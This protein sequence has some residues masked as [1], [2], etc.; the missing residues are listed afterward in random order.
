MLGSAWP[1]LA[2]SC[3]S[4]EPV[5]ACEIYQSTDVIFRGHVLDDNHDPT[6]GFLQTTLY[7]FKVLEAYKGL[8]PDTQQ[9][10]V[11]PGSMTT[12]YREFTRDHDYLVYAGGRQPAP[13]AVS[14]YRQLPPGSSV[15]QIPNAWKLLG[16][17][18]VYQVNECNPTRQIDEG[19][20]DLFFLRSS[21]KRKPS[22]GWIEGRAVQ[23][24]DSSW[25]A[26]RFVSAR[27]AVFTIT[28]QSRIHRTAVNPDGTFRIGPVPPGVYT[29]VAR[30]SLLGWGTVIEPR[31]EVPIGGCAVVQA[32]FATKSSISGRVVNFRGGPAHGIR[33]ELG[34]LLSDGKVRVIPA[35]WFDTGRDGRFTVS[36][37]PVGRIVLA[38]NLNGAPTSEMPFDPNYVPGTQDLSKAR[39]FEIKPGQEI[40]DIT[41]RLLKPLP[42]GNLYVHVKWPDGSAA[43]GGARASAYWNGSQAALVLRPAKTN[44]VKLRLALN[45][46]YKIRADWLNFK[47]GRFLFVESDGSQTVDFTKSGQSLEIRLKSSHP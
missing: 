44:R 1:A 32:T 37:V 36:D 35:T 22:N 41:L 23:N 12:C 43:T 40:T 7:R 20:S 4:S 5:Q 10:F 16:R 26:F 42:F 14:I 18:P 17:I 33:L 47:P 24:L 19:D 39:V 6:A 29:V 8:P 25:P 13:M 45:R 31:V 30:S 28:G 21:A 2:C 15:K 46:Q 27:D 34:E 9:V 3:A 38:A 11:D